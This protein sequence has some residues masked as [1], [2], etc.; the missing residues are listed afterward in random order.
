MKLRSL[1]ALLLAGAAV[2]APM[3]ASAHRAWIVPSATNL[4]GEDPW[5]GIDAAISNDL[6]YAD[7]NPMRLNGVTITAPDGQTATAENPMTGKYRSTFDLHLTQPGTYRI[8]NVGGGLTASFK[9]GEETRRWR[10]TAAE[11]ATA[12]PEGA[13][14]VVVTET[15]NRVETYVTRGEPTTGALAATG[16]GLEMVPVTHPTDLAAGEPATFKLMLDGQPAANLTVTVAPGGV[17]Y[18]DARG[19]TTVT[20]GADGAFTV[21]WPEAGMYWLNASAR[22]GAGSVPG[23]TRSAAWTATVEVLP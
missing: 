22:G 17:R 10:G 15:A 1:A 6:F 16:Q 21:T 11:L 14:E 18:R 2:L 20:T 4:S 8:A 5:V 7:H 23:S 9:V 3:T 12:V 13:T 19:E